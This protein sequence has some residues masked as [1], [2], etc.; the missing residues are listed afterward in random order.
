MHPRYDAFIGELG[1]TLSGGQR[2][3]IGIAVH[4]SDAPIL[5]LRRAAPQLEDP[6]SEDIVMAGSSV[7][8]KAVRVDDHASARHAF[9]MRTNKPSAFCTGRCVEQGRHDELLAFA[10]I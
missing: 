7:L 9:V 1:V 8:R 5:I 2:Q 10:R 6:E 4:Y 3:R